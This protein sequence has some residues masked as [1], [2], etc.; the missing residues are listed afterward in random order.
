MLLLAV[1]LKPDGSTV[2]SLYSNEKVNRDKVYAHLCF[3]S[4]L[5]HKALPKQVTACKHWIHCMPGLT[6]HTEA[7]SCSDSL[8]C[9]HT[10]QIF[11]LQACRSLKH[12]S[13]FYAFLMV[14]GT[15]CCVSSCPFLTGLFVGVLQAICGHQGQY[16][17]WCFSTELY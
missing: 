7:L 15:C 2:Y 8:T 17:M 4:T 13:C 5:K 1:G 16:E 14:P 12:Y 3:F 9:N 6:V 10:I 11:V